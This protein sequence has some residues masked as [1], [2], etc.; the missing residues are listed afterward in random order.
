MTIVGEKTHKKRER[1]L[2]FF[3][4]FFFFLSRWCEKNTNLVRENNLH[5]HYKMS[6]FNQIEK[7]KLI[8][9]VLTFSKKIKKPYYKK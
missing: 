2:P 3:F 1:K 6:L 4:L 7:N 5:T 8:Y 9:L